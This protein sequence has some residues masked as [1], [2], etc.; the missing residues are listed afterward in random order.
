MLYLSL[1]Q[2][3]VVHHKTT[4][5]TLAGS[6]QDKGIN[7]V[8]ILNVYIDNPDIVYDLSQ[9]SQPLTSCQVLPV[10]PQTLLHTVNPNC[11]PNRLQDLLSASHEAPLLLHHV[12]HLLTQLQTP[13]YCMF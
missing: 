13:A 10:V 11:R 8:H 1:N 3:I 12:I 2:K 7:S 5:S 6:L 9:T 4:K